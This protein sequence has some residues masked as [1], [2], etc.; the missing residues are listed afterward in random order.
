M[1]TA[2]TFVQSSKNYRTQ[3]LPDS[4]LYLFFSSAIMWYFN[5]RI[6]NFKCY[7][8]YNNDNFL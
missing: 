1:A 2:V 8:I 3:K 5:N 7:Y 4:W 6:Y